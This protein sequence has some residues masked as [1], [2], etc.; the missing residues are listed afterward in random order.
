MTFS[1]HVRNGVIVLDD[2]APSPPEGT[3]VR[4]EVLAEPASRTLAER[5]KNVIGKAEGLPVDA[6][7]RLDDYLYGELGS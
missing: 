3:A 6:A 4:V 7:S 2:G 5:F 1:G